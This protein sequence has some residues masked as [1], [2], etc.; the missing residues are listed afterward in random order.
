MSKAILFFLSI[1]ISTPYISQAQVVLIDDGVRKIETANWRT[2]H[3]GEGLVDN[4]EVIAAFEQ[5]THEVGIPEYLANQI[6]T[7]VPI[8]NKVEKYWRIT[9]VSRA[10]H[11]IRKSFRLSPET[12]FIDGKPTHAFVSQDSDTSLNFVLIPLQDGSIH[13]SFSGS[14]LVDSGEL[15]LSPALQTM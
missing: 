2:T 12:V 6:N 7:L 13:V 9:L 1:F 10:D 8:A 15:L 14:T 4:V 5:A 3:F 11:N